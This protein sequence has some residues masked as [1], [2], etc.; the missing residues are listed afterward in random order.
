MIIRSEDDRRIFARFNVDVPVEVTLPYAARS[1]KGE[2]FDIDGGGVGVVLDTRLMPEMTVDLR[3][4][5]P[6]IASVFHGMAKV[7]W[8]KQIHEGKWRAGLEFASID[9]MDLA[10]IFSLAIPGT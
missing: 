4:H 8:T 10:K 3:I 1:E 7:A 9:L 6:D 2:C 5:T